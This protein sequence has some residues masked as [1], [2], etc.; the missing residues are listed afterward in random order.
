MVNPTTPAAT[1][2]WLVQKFG[3]T[4]VASAARWHAIATYARTGLAEGHRVVI[5]VSALGGVTNALEALIAAAAR[6]ENLDAAAAA[7]VGR[8]DALVRELGLDS[9]PG[10]AEWY[11]RLA[12]LIRDPRRTAG[13]NPWRAEVLALGELMASTV[14]AHA[15]EAAGLPVEWL[16]AREWLHALDI[17]NQSPW[18]ARLSVNC[19]CAPDAAMQRALARR[20][21]LLITQGFIA[22]HADGGT[23]ILG[24][25]GSDTSAAYF[26]ALLGAARVEIW[27]DVAGMFSANPKRVPHARLLAELDHEEAQ[28]IAT[29]GAKVLH[30]RALGPVRDAR[31]PMVIKD[32]A[33]PELVG[34]LI[35]PR[36]RAREQPSVKAISARTGIT[37][38]SMESI[39]MYQQVGFLADVFAI[40]KRHGLSVDLIGSAETNVTV[41]LDPTQNLVTTNVLEELCRDL[42]AVCRVKVIT[43]CAAITLVGRGMRSLLATLAPVLAEFGR[44]TVHLIS[45]SSNDLNLTFVVD[46]A[47]ADLVAP[48]HALLVRAGAMRI[49]DARA[50]GP[51]WSDLYGDSGIATPARPRWWRGRRDALLALAGASD[52]ARYVYALDQIRERASA[53]RSTL[54]AVDRWYYAMKAN[55]HPDVLRTAH[56]AGFGIE[57]VSADELAAVDRALP[58]LAREGCLFTPN[59][60]P[61]GEYERAFARGAR[62]TV[63]ALHPLE[64]W[65]EVFRGREIVLRVDLGH[66]R[67]HHDKVITGGAGS[68]FG[69]PLDDLGRARAQAR[70]LDCRI[71]ALHAHLGSGVADVAHFRDTYAELAGI[72]EG[73]ADVS[74]LN[75]GGGLGVPYRPDDEPLDLIALGAALAELKRHYPQYRLWMEPGRYVVAEAGVLLAR[76][77]QVKR[78]HD[79]TYVGIETGMNSLLRPALYD[80]WHEIVNLT[81]LDEAPTEVSEVVGPICE[82]GDILGHKRRLPPT[83]EG[84]VLLIA[85]VGAYGAVMASRYNLRAPAAEVIL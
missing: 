32:S 73:F 35:G 3:G 68:K 47:R 83:R 72:A 4:S 64:C 10:L 63:D 85:D 30:P 40:F 75:I 28:E 24:R 49:D 25:G 31:V 59:F 76:V 17:P 82:S 9:A 19:A 2:T 60:A 77:T 21:P 42:E 69:V 45:Q 15:L 66:G 55:A 46:E 18:A 53:L 12:A 71:G 54:T 61:R 6:G 43:P 11:A 5:V 33:R 74:R 44:E 20:S 57:C 7:I 65:P 52:G 58:D 78:K 13:D 36:D 67:G 70:A 16:D 38:V 79:Y 34:T 50:F 51:R 41:S 62:V 1:P 37:L 27:T 26:G 8:H 29:T 81:R 14:G 56:G 80:A 22:R 48:L 84:D 23:A 39:G